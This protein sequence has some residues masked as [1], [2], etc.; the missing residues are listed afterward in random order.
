MDKKEPMIQISKSKYFLE[1][2]LD[3]KTQ[4]IISYPV[5]TVIAIFSLL[6]W[7]L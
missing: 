3:G 4:L 1:W 6:A 2:E 7:W 5:A